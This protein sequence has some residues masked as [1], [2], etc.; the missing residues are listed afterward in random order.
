MTRTTRLLLKFTL[1]VCCVAGASCGDDPELVKKRDEQRAEIRRLEGEL[2]LLEEKLNNPPKD[3]SAELRALEEQIE[4][5]KSEIATLERE[6][7]ELVSQKKE[8]EAELEQYRR[9]YPLR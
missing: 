7:P 2:M 9:D 8:L 6:I 1:A 5:D 3:R 4:R